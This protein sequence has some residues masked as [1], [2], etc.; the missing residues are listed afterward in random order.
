MFDA[1]YQRAQQ[2]R[3]TMPELLRQVLR[4]ALDDAPKR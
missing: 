1:V 3:V 4:R 2:E